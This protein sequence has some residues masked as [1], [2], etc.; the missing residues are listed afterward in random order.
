MSFEVKTFAAELVMNTVVGVNGYPIILDRGYSVFGHKDDKMIF[1]NFQKTEIGKQVQQSE[2]G[3]LLSYDWGDE[4]KIL[5]FVKNK[6]Y[7]FLSITTADINDIEN[8]I[9]GTGLF[10]IGFLGLMLAIVGSI[11]YKLLSNKL[12]PLEHLRK[13]IETVSE[14]N[15]GERIIITSSDE[16]SE[17]SEKMIEFLFQL[18]NV[19]RNI[20]NVSN[21][22]A[23]SS[24]EMSSTTLSFSDNAQSQAASAEE[25]TATVEEVSAGIDNISTGTTDQFKKLSALI[26]VISSLSESIVEMN[27]Q[28]SSTLLSTSDMTV[29]AESG[30]TALGQMNDSME[31]IIKSSQEM[32]GIVGIINDISDKINLL[33][34]NAA[35]EAARA[36]DAGRG[37]AVVADEIS[38]LAEQTA[39]SI[40]DIDRLIKENNNETN[41]GKQNIEITVSTIQ[42]III[43]VNNLNDMMKSMSGQ[44]KI[45]LDRNE[46]VNSEAE[47]ARQRSDEIRN[48]TNEQKLAT[49]EIV[50]SI[51]SIN[52]L[53]QANASGSEEMSAN[54]E[55]IAA[56]AE[57]LKESVN[58]FKF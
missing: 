27:R 36:G 14:G 48:A 39:S 3:S 4:H 10:I 33:S 47:A 18:R 8:D 42:S 17:I 58:F 56:M 15:L 41:T 24:E 52:E 40:K 32:A 13:T 25:I 16:I 20:Q 34:L 57:S 49:D 19:I 5:S 28:I 30:N 45:Q 22:M 12:K 53:T 44:M 11:L 9:A 7:G 1:K 50:R 6:K 31:H 37:F 29:N 46:S 51:T 2:S 54:A 26:D 38:K 35:I 55:S 23:T 43:G 21:E